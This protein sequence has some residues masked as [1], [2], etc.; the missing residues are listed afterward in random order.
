MESNTPK[1][2]KLWWQSSYDRGLDILLYLW[3]DIKQA[4]PDAELGVA[5]GWD[6]FLKVAS[7]N[8]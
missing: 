5:Y 7:G 4:Y 2:H 8:A 3:P 1:H 6:L